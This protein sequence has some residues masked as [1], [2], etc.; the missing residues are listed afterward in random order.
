MTP[1]CLVPASEEEGRRQRGRERAPPLLV[2]LYLYTSYSA[3][4]RCVADAEARSTAH[5]VVALVEAV[6]QPRRL[7]AE[8][9][10][11]LIGAPLRVGTGLGPC[12]GA[13]PGSLSCPFRADSYILARCSPP[14]RW[15]G[16]SSRTGILSMALQ[17]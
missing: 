2:R 5:A 14:W 10:P 7:E 12:A 1:L 15:C 16:K 9:A 6:P 3:T 11:P 13:D 4:V 8:A 17:A